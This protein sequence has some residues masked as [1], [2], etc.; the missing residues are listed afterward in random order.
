MIHT[1][2]YL[3]HHRTCKY[4]RNLVARSVTSLESGIDF[5]LE[6]CSFFFFVC[7]V[8][9]VVWV[10]NSSVFGR[11]FFCSSC[12]SSMQLLLLRLSADGIWL[13]WKQKQRRGK[14]DVQVQ[15]RIF[16]T[17]IY[18]TIVTT[19]AQTTHAQQ[20]YT[21]H[22]TQLQHHTPHTLHIIIWNFFEGIVVW[23][24][25]LCVGTCT[26]CVVVFF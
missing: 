11:Q 12:N 10:S 23:C 8:C 20:T 2:S 18:D 24:L 22:Y 3:A 26:K 1:H 14:I 25:S 16:L 15:Y 21:S 19:L 7:S 17:L 4:K 9:A 13:L 5:F 6:H